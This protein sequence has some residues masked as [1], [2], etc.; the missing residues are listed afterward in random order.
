MT[1]SNAFGEPSFRNDSTSARVGGR[2]VRSYVALRINCS[3]S[4]LGLGE[5]PFVSRRFKMKESIGVLTH[6]EFWT[7]GASGRLTSLNDQWVSQ[8]A[9]SEIHFLS[10][11]MSYTEVFLCSSYTN[12]S[13]RTVTTLMEQESARIV[14]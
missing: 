3:L 12:H 13:A 14:I 7:C 6:F 2:P 11:L 9:P 8:A 1:F 4:A 10:S 5:R